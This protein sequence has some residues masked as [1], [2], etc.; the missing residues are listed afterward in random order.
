MVKFTLYHQGAPQ[1]RSASRNL[2]FIQYH[3]LD[4][5]FLYCGIIFTVFYL[6]LVVVR[7]LGR[8]CVRRNTAGKKDFEKSKKN[9]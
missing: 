3:S 5:I 7:K 2:N 6:L 1:L 8:K 4:A 9:L